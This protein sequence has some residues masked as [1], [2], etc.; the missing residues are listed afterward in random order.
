[1][2]LLETV[3]MIVFKIQIMMPSE[4]I[5]S[6]GFVAATSTCVTGISLL[7]IILSQQQQR[8]QQTCQQVSKYICTSTT[9]L[10]I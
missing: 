9:E 1:M 10:T 2:R 5:M 3:K 7:F 8:Q 4:V 6:L